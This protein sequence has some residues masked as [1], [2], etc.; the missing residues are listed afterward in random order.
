MCF[1]VLIPTPFT[2]FG[3][4]HP[5]IKAESLHLKHILIVP[6]QVH[7]GGVQSQ[8]EGN[9]VSV[10]KATDLTVFSGLN[11]FADINVTCNRMH[12]PQQWY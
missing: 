3:C 7:C 8:N 1:N 12:G 9:C 2:R 11:A 5:Q 6:F 4:K 10:Q